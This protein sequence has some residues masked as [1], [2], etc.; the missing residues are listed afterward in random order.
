MF[1]MIGQF[2]KRQTVKALLFH[3]RSETQL[4]EAIVVFVDT[5]RIRVK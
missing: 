3:S 2:S 5:T 4:L 1:R